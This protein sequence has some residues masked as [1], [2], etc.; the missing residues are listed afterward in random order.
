MRACLMEEGRIRLGKIGI[1]SSGQILYN[2]FRKDE[3]QAPCAAGFLDGETQAE[4][5]RIVCRVKESHET[6]RKKERAEVQDREYK[7]EDFYKDD[8]DDEIWQVNTFDR[9]GEL[10]FS[11]DKHRVFNM[12]QDYPYALTAKEK[13]IFDRQFPFW[14]DFFKDRS[15][16]E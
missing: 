5:V 8:P 14:A 3:R 12:F 2:G 6:G 10:L 7:D 4:A 1:A 13:E 15:I 9:V 16:S 11:F